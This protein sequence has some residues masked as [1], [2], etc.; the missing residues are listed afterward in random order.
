MEGHG[1]KNATKETKDHTTRGEGSIIRTNGEH[2]RTEQARKCSNMQGISVRKTYA[3][4]LIYNASTSFFFLR[5]QCQYFKKKSTGCTVLELTVL[6]GQNGQAQISSPPKRTAGLA[7]QPSAH[8]LDGF[9]RS[10]LAAQPIS[11]Q[12]AVSRACTAEASRKCGP[13]QPVNVYK[14]IFFHFHEFCSVVPT[15][16]FQPSQCYV[17]PKINT[18][19]V[20]D[21]KMLHILFLISG[22]SI[23]I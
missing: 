16:E 21:Y 23:Y 22:H 13:T 5:R 11:P 19:S 20:S 15:C 8:S 6:P 7:G 2:C 12:L 17:H 18:T 10:N 9:S 14:N 1:T 3:K 4:L